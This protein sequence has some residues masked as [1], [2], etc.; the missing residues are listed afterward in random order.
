MRPEEHF[1]RVRKSANRIAA[2]LGIENPHLDHDHAVCQHDSAALVSPLSK[3]LTPTSFPLHTQHTDENSTP[4]S[5]SRHR[6]NWF[7]IVV[8]GAQEHDGVEV[9]VAFRTY[10]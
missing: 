5:V 10:A 8:D 9:A 1:N 6:S 2:V 4:S 3:V 7:C